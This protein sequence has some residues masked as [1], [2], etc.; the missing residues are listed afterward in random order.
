MNRIAIF[1][2]VLLA[3]CGSM[4]EF[5]VRPRGTGVS[6]VPVP[7]EP[8]ETHGQQAARETLDVSMFRNGPFFARRAQRL[9]ACGVE[10]PTA[11]MRYVEVIFP[12]EDVYG[13]DGFCCALQAAQTYCLMLRTELAFNG[14]GFADVWD[15]VGFPVLV[16][17]G[18]R[19]GDRDRMA[20]F[21]EAETIDGGEPIKHVDECFDVWY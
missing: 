21:C 1:T 18:P 12:R 14:R 20:L 10:I 5:D 4:P 9:V 8:A 2:A 11:I 13:P 15:F 16:S 6:A 7:D 17:E 3:G 19:E